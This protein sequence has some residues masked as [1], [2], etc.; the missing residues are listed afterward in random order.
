MIEGYT[1]AQIPGG[2]GMWHSLN[3]SY[4]L[5]FGHW[6]NILFLVLNYR[7]ISY[8]EDDDLQAYNS[9]KKV[10][11]LLKQYQNLFEDLSIVVNLRQFFG[12]VCKLA[13]LLQRFATDGSL[14][15]QLEEASRLKAAS[16]INN[17]LNVMLL[18]VIFA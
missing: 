12:I 3:I 9:K 8:D 11:T 6:L 16:T 2:V 14:K 5:A 13:M 18:C 15:S 10:A 1:G 7:H 4:S 17:F